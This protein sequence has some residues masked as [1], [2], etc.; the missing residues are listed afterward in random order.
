M[1]E[2]YLENIETDMPSPTEASDYLDSLHQR[3]LSKGSINNFAAAIIKYQT[4]IKMPVRLS[5][6]KLNNSLPYYFDE[7]DILKIFDVCNNIKHLCMRKVLFFGCLRSSELC[8]LD[9]TD[10]DPSNLTLR[11]EKPRI[12]LMLLPM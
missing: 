5:F 3:K 12:D 6:M 8:N 4:M 9:I 11:C 10:Y 1:A 7:M 2:V